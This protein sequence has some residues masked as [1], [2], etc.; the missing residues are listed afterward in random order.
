MLVLSLAGVTF[1]FFCWH[2]LESQWI[3]DKVFLIG[4]DL[5]LE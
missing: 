1:S 4:G 3:W 5:N 2:L